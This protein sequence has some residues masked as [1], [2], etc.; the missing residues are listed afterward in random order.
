MLVGGRGRAAARWV[1]AVVAA[2]AAPA[3]CGGGDSD[4]RPAADGRAPVAAAAAA[5][6]VAILVYHHLAQPPDGDRHASLWVAPQRFRAQVRALHA[7][8][9]HA[10]TLAQVHEAWH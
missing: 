9:V 3:S 4:A 7:A 1:L 6:A 5:P 2:A 8:G 10:V